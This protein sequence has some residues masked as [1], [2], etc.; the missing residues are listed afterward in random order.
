MPE[1][2]TSPTTMG[3]KGASKPPGSG[4][5]EGDDGKMNDDEFLSFVWKEFEDQKAYKHS[6]VNPADWKRYAM[7]YMAQHWSGMQKEWQSTPTISLITAAVNSL[8][9]VITDNRPQIAVIPRQPEHEIIATVIQAIVEWLW[10]ENDCDVKLPGTMLNTLIFGNGF[11]KI[12][13]DPSKGKGTGDISIV[14]VDPLCMFFN[15]EATSIDDADIIV[16]VE[17][18]SLRRVAML[19]PDKADQVLEKIKDPSITVDRPQVGQRPGGVRSSYNIPT[20]SNSD[21]WEY[22]T[23]FQTKDSP[24]KKNTVTV[25]ER[26]ALDKKSLRWKKSVVTPDLVLEPEEETDFSMAPFVHFADYKLPWS[27]WASGEVGLVE[28]LQYEINKRRGM[29]LD[30]LRYCAS[31]LI[32][33]DPGAGNDLENLEVEPG[34]AIPAEGGPQSVAWMLPQMDLGGLFQ[35]QDRDKQDMNSILGNVEVMQGVHPPGVDAGV[36]LE[37]LAD[38]AAA[39]MRPKIRLMEAS[40]RRTGKIMIHYIQKHYTAMR[41]FRIVGQDA[42]QF[43]AV[44]KPSGAEPYMGEDGQM[45]GMQPTFDAQSNVIPEDAEFDVRI[46]AGST[47]PVSKAAKFQQAITLFDRG[48]LPMRELLRASGWDKWQQIAQEMEQAQQ[49]QAQAQQGAQPGQPPPQQQGQANQ[50]GQRPSPEQMAQL[51]GMH[52]KLGAG[53]R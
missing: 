21:V 4:G 12:L 41:V 11:W 6:Q 8:L 44:N 47:L 49:Q 9:A 42:N 39:R 27:I 52:N 1:T 38:A 2:N 31:P 19:W 22:R 46:G 37:Q 16:H 40:L 29:I 36:A 15:P 3:D 53:P 35:V 26:W 51:M 50:P 18:M 7:L 33:Y 23:P 45:A 13:W 14:N 10:E 43:F 25:M 24:H 32:V 30:I 48:A 20:T 28:N 34:K 5:D 17:Q